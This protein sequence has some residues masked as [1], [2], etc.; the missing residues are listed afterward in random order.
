MFTLFLLTAIPETQQVRA[1]AGSVG[2]TLPG[3]QQESVAEEKASAGG[4][5]FEPVKVA[6]TLKYTTRPDSHKN[7][8]SAGPIRQPHVWL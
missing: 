5:S 2:S 7:T 3:N 8:E 6:G 4:K 1:A